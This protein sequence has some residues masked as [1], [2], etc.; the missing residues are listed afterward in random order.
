MILELYKT[1]KFWIKADRIG[2][3]IPISHWK[4]FFK[5]TM[6]RLCK[7]KFN[8]FHHT[9]YFRPG[10]YAVNC[11][12]ISIGKNVVIR[13]GTMLF[14]DDNQN[15]VKIIIED[16]VLIGSC[17]HIYVDNHRFDNPEIP[18][19]TQGYYKSKGVT[20]KRGCWIGAYSI[21]LPGV[22]V[23]ENSVVGAGSV[24]TKSM[25]SRVLFAGNPAKILRKI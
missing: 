10:A 25:P 15:G 9:A 21:L 8:Y 1:V 17:V 7:A 24:V 13:P 6:L 23:G 2:P 14:S 3:D 11:T 12:N 22:E 16:N 19:I 18:I 5:P 20:L 4:L